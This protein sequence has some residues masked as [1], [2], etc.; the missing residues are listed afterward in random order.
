MAR[1]K[2]HFETGKKKG[3]GEE[4]VRKYLLFAFKDFLEKLAMKLN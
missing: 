1:N 3:M 4:V 2:L